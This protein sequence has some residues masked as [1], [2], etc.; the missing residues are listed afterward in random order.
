MRPSKF[1]EEP[2]IEKAEVV[3]CE[4]GT[5]TLWRRT[6]KWQLNSPQ[7]PLWAVH[8]G[9]LLVCLGLLLNLISA[10]SESHRRCLERFNAYSPVLDAVD[11]DFE[12]IRFVYSLW[13]ESPWKGPP[14]P[15]VEEAWQ[16][17]MKWGQI[18]I[19]GDDI[20]R[21]G[22]NLTAVQYPEE[23]GGQYLATAMGTHAIHCLHFIWK[24]HYT[25]DLADVRDMKAEIPELYNRHYEHCVDYIRQELMCKFDTTVMPFNWVLD[26]QNP[27]PNGNTIH[28]CVNWDHLQDWLKNRAVEMP[29]GFKWHQP[30]G[31]YRLDWNP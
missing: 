5:S 6:T 15:A 18:S 22:H 25:D 20:L 23:L 28:K 26:H 30:P 19:T 31:A 24:D 11:V 4:A 3:D 21:I 29:E 17:L 14:T 16:S 1:E 12:E 7:I 13:S 8:G 27:T 10:R 9:Y 2:F